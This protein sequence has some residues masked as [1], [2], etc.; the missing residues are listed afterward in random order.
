MP[1]KMRK[2]KKIRKTIM[3][4]II[5][6]V[7]STI[8][9]ISYRFY[10]SKSFAYNDE[11][12]HSKNY[13]NG[14]FVNSIPNPNFSFNN[15]GKMVLKYIKGGQRDRKPS[16]TLPVIE[17]GSEFS[18]IASKNLRFAWLG[19]SSI[20]IEFE[21]KRFLFDPVFSERA[22]IV[23]WIGP[24]RFHK[25]PIEVSNLPK[26][27]AVIISHDHYDHLDK[28]VIKQIGNQELIFLVPLGI[29]KR[30]E[31]WGIKKSKIIEFDWWDEIQLGDITIAS[32][33]A[34]HYSGRGIFDKD[35]TL[36]CS[37]ALICKNHRVFIS[38]DTG[39]TPEFKKISKKYAPFN[40]SFMK[41][42]A[43]DETWSYIQI[44]PEEAIQI[45]REIKADVLV[46]THWATFDL[47]LHSWYEPIERL[48]DASN[49]K[50][51][52]VLTPKVGEIVNLKQYENKYWWKEFK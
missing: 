5:I 22:S 31:G 8:F 27:D 36:W 34:R 24:K 4:I 47:G 39:M 48:I 32:T 35:L 1:E 37:W 52:K 44:N 21:N 29:G 11:I 49:S 3:W 46:P 40:I 17:I 10:L 51:T 50:G 19:H 42:G 7:V 25:S 15:F 6:T 9:A 18:D 26:L 16:K 41:I 14:K 20:M 33:P 2:I 23:Q 30:L 12:L 43:Y 45:Q 13:N 38:G 28:N